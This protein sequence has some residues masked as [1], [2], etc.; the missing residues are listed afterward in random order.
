MGRTIQALTAYICLILL[1]LP[2]AAVAVFSVNQGRF[3]LSWRGFTLMWYQRLLENEYILE[4]AFN[5]LVLAAVSTV[6]ATVIGTALALGL[7]RSPWPPRCQRFFDV[8]IN[9]PVV[10]PDIIMAVALVLA[11]SLLRQLSSFFELGLGTMILGHVTF[12]ISFVTL[13]V[14]SR[15]AALNRDTREAAQDLFASRF[16]HFRRV[17]LPLILPGILAG[18]MLAFTLSL[19]DFIISFFIHGPE[20]VT[21]PIFIF[22]SLKRGL[23]PEINA[24][25]T[26]MLGATVVL[27]VAAE[28]LTRSRGGFSEDPFKPLLK[29]EGRPEPD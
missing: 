12:Q 7:D 23:T 26:I 20:S 11:F 19:D 16:Y 22:A 25:S 10:V 13:I 27:A 18:A 29:P 17:T 3:G 14:R 5:S 6:L 24:I 21:L 15:L 4:A 1:Y 28:R 8:I 2:S 9:I